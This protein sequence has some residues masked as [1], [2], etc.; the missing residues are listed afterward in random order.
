MDA[1]VEAFTPAAAETTDPAVGL[2]T[3]LPGKALEAPWT[4]PDGVATP[5]AGIPPVAVPALL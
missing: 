2:P 1:A 4:T 5:V 3:A